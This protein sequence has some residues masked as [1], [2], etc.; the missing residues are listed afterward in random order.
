MAGDKTIEGRLNKQEAKYELIKPGKIMTFI[1]DRGEF[2]VIV[3]NVRKYNTFREMLQSEN[4]DNIL[5]C[6]ENVEQAVDAYKKI[7]GEKDVETGVISI[8]FD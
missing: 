2:D 7:Y 4:I 5:P 6:I 1:G 3:K 8:E